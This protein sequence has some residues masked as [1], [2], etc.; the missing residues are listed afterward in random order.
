METSSR[1]TNGGSSGGGLVGGWLDGQPGG[2]SGVLT[3]SVTAL[4]G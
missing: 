2:L 4:G 3:D 1:Q